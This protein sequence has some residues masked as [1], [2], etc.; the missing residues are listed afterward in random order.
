MYRIASFT[1]RKGRTEI[2]ARYPELRI[3]EWSRRYSLQ[4]SSATR[5]SVPSVCTCL[6]ESP[7]PKHSVLLSKFATYCA[8]YTIIYCR[9]VL[10]F[11][12]CCCPAFTNS[13]LHTTAYFHQLCHIAGAQYS[14]TWALI[15]SCCSH[16]ARNLDLRLVRWLWGQVVIQDGL[17]AVAEAEAGSLDILIIDA[18]GGDASQV[19][20]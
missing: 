19:C 14:S 2:P 17:Q 7:S 20:L 18:D 13:C 12:E 15:R 8:V 16:T 11:C 3:C 5:I 1:L 9:L 6:F 4:Q 10:L